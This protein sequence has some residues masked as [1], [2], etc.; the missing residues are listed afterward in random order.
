LAPA[1]L[2]AWLL[3]CAHQPGAFRLTAPGNVATLVPPDAKDVTVQQALVRTPPVVRKVLC[4]ASPHG[5]TINKKGITVTRAAIEAT[6]PAELFAW[7]IEL[8]KQGCLPP[9]QAFQA[10]GKIIDALPLPLTKRFQ[11]T[12]GRTDLTPG[13]S[14]RVVAPVLTPGAAANTPVID[15]GGES[16][17]PGANGSIDVT[18]KTN[19]AVIGYEIDW[20]DFTPQEGGPGYRLTP[21]TAEVHIGDR[22]E[23]PDTPTISRFQF[24]AAARWYELYMMTK[25]SSNDFDFVVFSAKT[26][27]DLANSVASFQSDAAKFLAT[28]DPHS[29][30]VLPHGSGINAYTRVKVH[31]AMVDLPKGSSVRQAIG[32]DPAPL[33]PHLKV[34]KLHNGKLYPVVWPPGTNQIL[35]L[36]LEGGEEIDW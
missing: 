3:G 8:E 28:S 6:A 4:P 32:Q 13:N 33:L 16:V 34:Q 22:V 15:P 10:A 31:G 1:V 27:E 20:Y 2:A 9:N 11:L 7:T 5:L 17:A 23:H 21:R 26:S 14:L 30:T 12:Q 24:G 25:V 18:L 35:S 19:P 36:V 29:Y